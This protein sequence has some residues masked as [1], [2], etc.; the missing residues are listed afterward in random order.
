[1]KMRLN[2]PVAAFAVLSLVAAAC[3]SDSEPT[4]GG[5]TSDELGGS[6]FAPTVDTREVTA[7]AGNVTPVL[8][9]GDKPVVKVGWFG[10]LTGGT[11]AFTISSKQ[12][13]ELAIEQANEAGNLAVTLKF[14]AQDNKDASEA[15]APS[16]EQGFIQDDAVVGVIGGAFSGET[17]AVGELFADAGLT[18]IS[19]SA[20]NPDITKNG[21]PFF[22]LLSTDAVQAAKAA[23]L[24]ENLGC[25][26]VAVINDKSDYGQGL[27]DLVQ[28]SLTDA[29]VEVTLTE[30]VEP[31]TDYTALVDSISADAPELVFYGGY[32]PQASLI[33]K[34]MR[35]KGVDAVFMSG[36]GT[37]DQT[38]VDDA[39]TA[40]AE[41]VI[42]TCPCSDPTAASDDASVAFVTAYN[43]RWG[44]DPGIYGAEGYD[45][46]NLMVAAID[47]SDDDGEVT[48]EE[49]FAFFDSAEGLEGLTKDYTWDETGEIEGGVIIGYV[50]RDGAIVQLGSV[51]DI[52]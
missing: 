7:A 49:I 34:Q 16:I 10:D 21:W 43:E 52:A 38:F 13:A 44:E 22:R 14:V 15:T 32:G 23:E 48:R 24:I 19:P 12:A 5:C 42:L 35:E 36:D 20:T 33:L 31:A 9:Q 2:M 4:A 39:G 11:S 17:L 47:A 3:S 1:M 8:G 40:N 45:G 18:H 41:G 37:K 27:A 26:K 28:S 46:G 51:D 50:I 30:G 25:T 6:A 29:G